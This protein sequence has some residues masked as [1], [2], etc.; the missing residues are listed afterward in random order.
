M[1]KSTPC[2][3]Q[4][5]VLAGKSSGSAKGPTGNQTHRHATRRENTSLTARNLGSS[6]TITYGTRATW[7][8]L[9]A[10]TVPSMLSAALFMVMAIPVRLMLTIQ[11]LI[12][13]LRS[14]HFH[15]PEKHRPSLI[16]ISSTQLVV[17]TALWML[18]IPQPT[19]GR[20]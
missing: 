20:L 18:T 11:L 8:R 13:G 6:C 5:G 19:L 9:Q 14:L 3:D 16:M 2:I 17:I 12:Y 15:G 10:M 4:P 7:E 1:A